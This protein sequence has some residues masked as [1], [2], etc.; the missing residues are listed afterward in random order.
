MSFAADHAL[1]SLLAALIV[2]SGIALAYYLP[3]IFTLF[4]E[5]K[6][7]DAEEAQLEI[8]LADKL[9]VSLYIALGFVLGV[10][11]DVIGKLLQQL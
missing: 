9:L 3:V 6:V 7:T 2:G 4:S 5:P 1:W 10:Y 11:P 8:T